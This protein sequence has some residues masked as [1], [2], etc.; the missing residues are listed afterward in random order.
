M[1]RNTSNTWRS[2]RRSTASIVER[3]GGVLVMTGSG[4][5]IIGPFDFEFTKQK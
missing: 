3:D 4:R 2:D 1:M 5:D